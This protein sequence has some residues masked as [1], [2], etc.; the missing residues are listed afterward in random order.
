M[1]ATLAMSAAVTGVA[2]WFHGEGIAWLW[3]GLVILSVVPFTL[4]VIRPTNE[5]LLA[6]GRDL[7]SPETLDLLERWGRLHAVRSAL[8]LAASVVY[9]YALAHI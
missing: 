5:R 3:G 8:G 7:A 2:T 4:V 9:L 6:P 1:Q